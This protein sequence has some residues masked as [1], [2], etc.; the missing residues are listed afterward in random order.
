MANRGIGG[1]VSEGMLYRLNTVINAHPRLC[2]LEC[3]I[4]DVLLDVP[5]TDFSKNATAIVSI[6]QQHDITPVLT[7][8]V[9]LGSNGANAAY[10]PRIDSFNR[11]LQDIAVEKNCDVMDLNSKLCHNG[12]LQPRYVLKDGLHFTPDAYRV[13]AGMVLEQIKGNNKAH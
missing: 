11:V 3:G 2:F 5:V 4:N 8:I 7:S 12:V 13:W 10:S 1:D 6:L 9:Y